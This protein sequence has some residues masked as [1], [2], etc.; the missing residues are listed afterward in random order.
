MSAEPEGWGLDVE[1]DSYLLVT[2]CCGS[3]LGT[4][5][6]LGNAFKGV[7]VVGTGGVVD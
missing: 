3:S 5:G 1:G 7:D 2:E 6:L 4:Q